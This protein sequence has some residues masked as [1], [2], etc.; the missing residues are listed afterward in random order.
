MFGFRTQYGGGKST[1]FALIYEDQAAMKKFEPHYRLVRVGMAAKKE[2]ASRQQRKSSPAT[3]SVTKQGIFADQGC[4]MA[5]G[6]AVQAS[7]ARTGRRSSGVW[8]RSRAVQRR[9]T[10]NRWWMRCRRVAW[11]W[12]VGLR[13][14]GRASFRSALSHCRLSASYDDVGL[15]VKQCIYHASWDTL[16]SLIRYTGRAVDR[17]LFKT[18]SRLTSF[19]GIYMVTSILTCC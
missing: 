12:V 15:R 3:V 4:K 13:I 2:K 19:Q 18:S 6:V 8:R 10:R 1:G 11:V 9:R 5:D 7:S 17:Q 14:C 16:R